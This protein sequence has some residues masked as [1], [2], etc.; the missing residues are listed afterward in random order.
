[1]MSGMWNDDKNLRYK[2]AHKF[3][4]AEMTT[5]EFYY[6]V[7]A[8]RELAKDFPESLDGQKLQKKEFSPIRCIA[9]FNIGKLAGQSMPHFHLQYG[10]DVV[11]SESANPDIDESLMNLFYSELKQQSLILWE[12]E[13]I[14]ILAPWTPKGQYHMEIHF[15]NKYELTHLDDRDIKILSYLSDCFLRIYESLSIR[16]INIVYIG[17]PYKKE[18]VPFHVQFIPRSNTTAIYEMI[19]VNV[20]DTSPSEIATKFELK[21]RDIISKANMYDIEALYTEK[22]SSGACASK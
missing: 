10:W 4:F 20:V 5:V 15:K 2:N 9:G 3:L 21:W 13:R 8:A 12:D 11:L 19:G 16:N 22:F 18:N 17:S 14:I 6:L 1:M 7:L